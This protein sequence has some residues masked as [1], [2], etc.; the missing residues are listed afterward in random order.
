MEQDDVVIKYAYVK[1]TLTNIPF[2]KD[3]R[4]SYDQVLFFLGDN[5][6]RFVW[7]IFIPIV[8]F[9]VIL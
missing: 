9:I 1:S 5:A 8:I 4:F 2:L 7:V 6:E 3:K